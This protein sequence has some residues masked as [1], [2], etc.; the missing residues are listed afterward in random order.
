[1]ITTLAGTDPLLALLMAHLCTKEFSSR[2]I[3]YNFHPSFPHDPTGGFSF[4]FF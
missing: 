3:C 2:N 1:M 4:G